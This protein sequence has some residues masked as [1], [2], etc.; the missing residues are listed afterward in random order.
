MKRIA[1]FELPGDAEAPKLSMNLNIGAK[2]RM[3]DGFEAD[4]SGKYSF[5]DYTGKQWYFSPEGT[6]TW[7]AGDETNVLYKWQYSYDLSVF[8]AK[9]GWTCWIKLNPVMPHGNPPIGDEGDT[10]E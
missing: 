10:N 7:S 5:Y 6:P 3:Q 2:G 9:T 1:L 4:E 8:D